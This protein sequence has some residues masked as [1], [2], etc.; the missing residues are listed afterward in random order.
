M[1]A[2]AAVGGTNVSVGIASSAFAE[3]V[4][5]PA[6]SMKLRYCA[7]CQG[8]YCIREDRW[9]RLGVELSDFSRSTSTDVPL[10]N[11]FVTYLHKTGSRRLEH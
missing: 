3:A 7:I 11:E 9:G 1:A 5:Y 6:F 10:L 2:V 4:I 8:L